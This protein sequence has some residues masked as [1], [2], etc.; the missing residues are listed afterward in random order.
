MALGYHQAQYESIPGNELNTPTLST[1]VLFTPLIETKPDLNPDP[2][3]RDDENRNLDEPLPSIPEAFGPAWNL[4]TRAYPDLIGFYLKGMLGA[5]TTTAGNGVIT[6][7]AGVV[8]PTNAFR[9]VFTSPFLPAGANPQ[10]MQQHFAYKDQGVF[11]KAKGCATDSL[12][13]DSPQKG[14]VRL[15]VSGPALYLDRESDPGLTTAYESPTIRPFERSGLTL[16]TWLASTS[17]HEDFNLAVAAPVEA[18]PSLGIASKYPDVME[19]GDGL[20]MTTGSVPQRQLGTVDWDAMKN[21]TT[22]AALAQ[23][24]SDSLVTGAYPYKLFCQMSACQYVGGEVDPLS[25]KRRLGAT[26]NWKAVNAGSASVI[27]TVVNG[28]SSYI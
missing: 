12:S 20:I 9:H 27:W 14:G 10:T 7:P 24:I 21:N 5:P 11:F 23:W 16:P 28:T 13:V 8:I 2:M 17:T 18:T 25:N 6:D 3:E 4:E 19:K 15:K 1:K 22:F 26:F